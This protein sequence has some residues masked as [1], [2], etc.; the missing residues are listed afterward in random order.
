MPLGLGAFSG[1]LVDLF[2]NVGGLGGRIVGFEERPHVQHG[3]LRSVIEQRL[4]LEGVRVDEPSRDPWRRGTLG[5]SLPSGPAM[6]TPSRP[7]TPRSPLGPTGP[8]RSIRRR[9]LTKASSETLALSSAIVARIDAFSAC[10]EAI[11]TRSGPTF[12]SVM[13]TAASSVSTTIP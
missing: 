10:N 11:F 3:S 5:A 2:E 6:P 13:L 9:S 12:S 7:S 8:R 4:H 1:R